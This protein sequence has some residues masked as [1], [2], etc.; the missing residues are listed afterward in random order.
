MI[1]LTTFGALDLTSGDG[2]AGRAVLAQ[3]KRVA[4]LVYLALAT[5]RGF[6]RRDAL[7]TLF[8]PDLDQ[9]RA[10]RA[11]RDAIYF[12]RKELGQEIV[13]GRGA[14]EVALNPTLV[15]TDAA[16]FET[17]LEGGDATGA[18]ALVSGP[19][20][21]GFHLPD[22][23][24]FERWLDQ[25]R[26][27]LAHRAADAARILRDAAARAGEPRRAIGLARQVLALDPR[28]EPD[29]RRLLEILA[30][31]GDLASVAAEYDRFAAR[32]REDFASRPD[33]ETSSLLGR[34]MDRTRAPAPAPSPSPRPAEAE[35]AG[36]GAGAGAVL[37][38]NISQGSR[39]ASDPPTALAHRSRR[40]WALLAAAVVV[41]IIAVAARPWWSAR[42]SPPS[43]DVVVL[44]FTV[45]GSPEVH[46]LGDGMVDL[47]SSKLDGM[48]R[49]R[50]VD[51]QAL[52]A[53]L[54]TL[55]QRPLDLA[56]GRE[57]AARFGG[58]AFVMG[59]ILEA[60]GRLQVSAY[61]Y[62][63]EGRQRARADQLAESEAELFRVVDDLVRLL[64]AGR[65]DEPGSQ[66]ARLA[67]L[68]TSSLPA[69]KAYL[70]GERLMRAGDFLPA[71]D[72]FSRAVATDTA[73]ALA[74]YRLSSAADWA[75]RNG[76]ARR[77][78]ARAWALRERLPEVNR[79]YVEAR[80]EFWHGDA[81]RA[82]ALYHQ[83]TRTQPT[84]VE[85]WYE[86]AEVRFHGGPW[87]GRPPSEATE[88]F[89]EVLRLAPGHIA[90]LLHLARLM[91]LAGDAA[92]VDSLARIAE[93]LEPGHDRRF[94]FEALRVGLSGD[95]ADRAR[96]LAEVADLGVVDLG[97]VA[98]R[99]AVYARDL[100]TAIE[101][102]RLM[103]RP[104]H[105]EGDHL[106][107][108]SILAH[109]LFGQ[110]HWREAQETLNRLARLDPAH[111][112]HARA[113]MVTAPW[114]TP[115]A[116][117]VAAAHEALRMLP[118]RP[119]PVDSAPLDPR[120]FAGTR[121]V[122]YIGLLDAL[123]GDT[124]SG[125]AAATQLEQHPGDDDAA[126]YARGLG[127]ALRA[128]MAW[129]AGDPARALAL[130]EASWP[131]PRRGVQQG[132]PWSY[133]QSTQRY[134]RA[135]LLDELGRHDEALR[136]IVSTDED[137]GGT[138]GMLPWAL[139]LRARQ[140]EQLG[141]A[142]EAAR[143]RALARRNMVENE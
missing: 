87:M 79:L 66:V 128:R 111:A 51:P 19:L 45:H 118:I 94:E 68:T 7:A 36:T 122:Y 81:A 112:A 92:A 114:F 83:L 43:G 15:E 28:S 12:L 129:R 85:A 95:P 5:P 113:A 91:A 30:D 49:F 26:N 3:P 65:L 86:L 131:P 97:Q 105:T 89:R 29:L 1:R 75:G 103:V 6:H 104:T 106:F 46:Y 64:L 119:E 41:A 40:Y 73:F 62:D 137:I 136:W 69:L 84:D 21:P 80:M 4:V 25:E 59:S 58:A 2:V 42:V 140:L 39:E 120:R 18:L 57:V 78:I 61:L 142:N 99:G 48:D 37:S 124:A 74:H 22:A 125:I 55:G 70:D 143:L 102:A 38:P 27:R 63:R 76:E 16:R 88:T 53:H 130:L 123:A 32:L 9:A 133:A 44:P 109:L 23:P 11:L 98:E 110:G 8:W 121:Q 35:S 71:M 52:F 77:A 24:E 20:L 139:A 14:E 116:E 126:L 13:A 96:L 115:P 34:L 93:A 117:D 90:A 138:P 60:G 107:G 54:A 135:A 56:L 17:L 108:L 141:Q 33:P 82:E 72:A 132:W 31:A 50:S 47:L 10:R 127:G 100:V 101:V 67:A 134:L